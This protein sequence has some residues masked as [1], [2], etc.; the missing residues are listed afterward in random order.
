MI[1]KKAPSD[2]LLGSEHTHRR[3]AIPMERGR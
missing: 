1:G 2:L 3:L